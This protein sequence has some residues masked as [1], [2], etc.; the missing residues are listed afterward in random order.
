MKKILKR[1]L[2]AVYQLCD[3][4]QKETA[5]RLGIS[6]VTLAKKLI[7]FSIT[8]RYCKS[9]V[10]KRRSKIITEISDKEIEIYK[11]QFDKIGPVKDDFISSHQ[12]TGIKNHT[13]VYDHERAVKIKRQYGY[14]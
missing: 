10:D 3:Y 4:N 8:E 11:K 14:Y 12:N 2:I 7:K 9:H 13:K 1:K 5:K 6:H